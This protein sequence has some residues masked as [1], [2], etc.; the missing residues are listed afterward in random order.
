MY[1]LEPSGVSYGY[2]GCAA[3]KAKS[4]AKTELEK[5]NIQEKTCEELV[6][7]AAKI[8]YM[9]HDEVKDKMFELELSWVGE[10]TNGVHK[11]VPDNVRLDQVIITKIR[12]E[13]N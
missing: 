8:I 4:N 11:R 3:G 7:E 1:C 10:F 9:V 5:I 12:I 2:W 13:N 6:K